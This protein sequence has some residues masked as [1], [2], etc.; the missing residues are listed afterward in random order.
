MSSRNFSFTSLLSFL[1]K[2]G[3]LLVI[4]LLTWVFM[5]FYYGPIILLDEYFP[6][7][8]NDY[9]SI[10]TGLI[11]FLIL[12]FTYIAFAKLI[13]KRDLLEL[14]YHGKEMFMGIAG[15]GRSFLTS[16]HYTMD[17]WLY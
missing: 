9:S 5:A 7:S 2:M 12:L 1:K 17:F 16:F 13:E 10:F 11:A 14:H 8:D 4:F 15:G 3:W 6:R